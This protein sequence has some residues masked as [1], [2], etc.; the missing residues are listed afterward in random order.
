LVINIFGSEFPNN[1]STLQNL[2][3]E[4]QLWSHTFNK[5]QNIQNRKGKKQKYKLYPMNFIQDNFKRK[6]I[7][8]KG[9]LCIDCQRGL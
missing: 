9:A 3:R 7:T 6:L 8:A 4:I 2:N 1:Y 5:I